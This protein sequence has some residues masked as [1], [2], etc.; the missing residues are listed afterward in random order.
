[1]D[2][3]HDT[4][5][6]QAIYESI[7]RVKPSLQAMPMTPATRL[8]SLG[9]ASIEIMSVVFEMEDVFEVS[10]VDRQLDTFRT[11]GEGRDVVRKLLDERNGHVPALA[12]E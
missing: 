1:M 3:P 11:I 7:W 10:I 12:A 8:S 2:I 6:E 4:A 9:L 5:I